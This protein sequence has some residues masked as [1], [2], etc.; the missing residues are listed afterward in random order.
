MDTERAKELVR[1]AA[2]EVEDGIVVHSTTPPPVMLG[3]NW[4]L[5]GV[6]DFIDKAKDIWISGAV[7]SH[8]LAVTAPYWDWDG[9]EKMVTRYFD[10]GEY[11]D[12]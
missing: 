3:A 12:K 8:R 1:N 7:P 5:A 4:D 2:V 9:K 11:N 10:I 6:E